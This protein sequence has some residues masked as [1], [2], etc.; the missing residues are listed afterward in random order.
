M[1][2][3]SHGNALPEGYRLLWYR[4]GRV[5]GQGGFGITYEAFD[6]NLEKAVAI[7]EYLPTEFAVR[8]ADTT[9][10]P[11]TEDRKQMFEWGLDR[12]L[13]EARTLA[14][15]HHPNI[16]LVHNVFE[17]NGT[18][19]MAMQYEQGEALHN[20]F[21]AE[22][23]TSEQELLNIA[24]PLLDGIEHMHESGFIHRDIK[25][26]NIFIR[27]DGTPVLL[28]FGSARFAIGEQTKTL[29]SLVSPCFA[30]YE[31][32]HNETG[33]QGPWTDIYG[34]GATLYA[35]INR[36]RGPL[37]AIVRGHARIEGK[38]DPME[39]A[40][41][42]GKGN[43]SEAFLKAIDVALGFTPAERPASV[44]E[45]RI[46]FT[47]TSEVP[48]GPTIAPTKQESDIA[49][50]IRQDAP[51]PS[52]A[53]KPR[54]W[55]W[56]AGIFTFVIIAFLAVYLL[57]DQTT[58]NDLPS[59]SQV[60][61]AD[62]QQR[63]VERAVQRALEAEAEQRRQQEEQARLAREADAHKVKQEQERM[64]L[65]RTRLEAERA[66]AA[67]QRAA[68]EQQEK[69]AALLT[70]ADRAMVASRLT[71]PVGDNAMEYFQS[72]LKLDESNIEAKKGIGQIVT[73]Y[74]ALAKSAA[75]KQEWDKVDI[76]IAKADSID[77]GGD[78]ILVTKSELSKQHAAAEEQLRQQ[79]EQERQRL[80][81]LERKRLE[82]EQR[83]MAQKAALE[84]T[85]RI[86]VVTFGEVP[87]KSADTM[88]K[89]LKNVVMKNYLEIKSSNTIVVSDTI[90][91]DRS[92]FNK[93]QF[94]NN[95]ARLC[96]SHSVDKILGLY[97][98]KNYRGPSGEFTFTGFDCGTKQPLRK[99]Y[100]I[101]F[102][103]TNW[104]WKHEWKRVFTAF[105]NETGFFNKS[106]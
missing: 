35:G 4:I 103:K 92:Y 17:K 102:D 42:I 57:L 96:N 59:E 89:K 30:P 72:V 94:V 10:R 66:K 9:V 2:S 15:F 70:E 90:E 60:S 86:A 44:A 91:N 74:L 48:A 8:D 45:W 93:D 53:P 81:E 46:Y 64:A 41:L 16:V 88:S 75:L 52:Q 34:L 73:R 14:K 21:R 1:S 27:L 104:T 33:K 23:L 65:E 18:A 99:T 28:D 85:L 36:G 11:F 78:A 84:S 69:I 54:Y 19:Y 40:T 39:P 62:Q 105:A 58:T 22:R 67:Q 71:S 51:T 100:D 79:Q 49:T 25:P 47:G 80:A 55:T 38:P 106:P 32:Y 95:S 50:V 20:L 76:Y 26:P 6:T 63:L 43:Y 5:L 29:T 82:E 31:Q 13:Q 24:L 37:D 87:N 98:F 12:F 83:M 97:F 61:E 101:E 7:K 68:N 56:A 77:P 3:K